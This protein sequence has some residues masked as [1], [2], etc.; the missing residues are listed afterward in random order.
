MQG[1]AI[2]TAAMNCQ[3]AGV[4]VHPKI[5][6]PLAMSKR[7]LQVL[8]D[9]LDKEKA[10]LEK[11]NN[12]QIPYTFGT[13]IELPRACIVA[14]QLAE[15]ADFFSYGTNDL[16]RTTFGISRDDFTYH[17]CYKK[18][19]ILDS[20]P[21]AVLDTEGVGK[22]IEMSVEKGKKVKKDL[23]CGICGEHGGEPKSIQYADKIGLDY[24]S[25]SPFR[26]PIARL[27]AA[28]AVV[29]NADAKK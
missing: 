29:K 27:A 2:F 15:L 18:L 19:G 9:I 1:K 4:K 24:V 3:K 12:V 13:M 6:I 22:L 21:F 20:D 23:M 10:E 8:K 16:T 26:I 5:M 14:D 7:E 28:Q 17:D 11:A 25:C